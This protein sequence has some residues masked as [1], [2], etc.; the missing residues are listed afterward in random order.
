[1]S[2]LQLIQ[3]FSFICVSQKYEKKEREREKKANCYIYRGTSQHL[4]EHIRTNKQIFI[5][6][7]KQTF[8][9]M[10]D[11]TEELIVAL[12]NVVYHNSNGN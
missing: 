7:M 3:D 12:N 11:Y 8:P 9:K 4:N 5:H 1:M 6:H 2:L 10:A